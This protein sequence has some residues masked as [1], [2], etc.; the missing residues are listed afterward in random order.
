MYLW[1]VTD[2]GIVFNYI[3]SGGLID[4]FFPLIALSLHN[5]QVAD[6]AVADEKSFSC[7]AEVSVVMLHAPTAAAMRS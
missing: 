5:K 6:D 2:A 7:D 3:L 1:I 4:F